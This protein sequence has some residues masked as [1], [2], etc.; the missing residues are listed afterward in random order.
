MAIEVV[1]EGTCPGTPTVTVRDVSTDRFGFGIA[2]DFALDVSGAWVLGAESPF[3]EGTPTSL[4][5]PGRLIRTYAAEGGERVFNPT[6]PPEYAYLCDKA[7][8]AMEVDEEASVAGEACATASFELDT[9][10]PGDGL[11]DCAGVCDGTSEL[12]P[13]GECYD[14]DLGGGFVDLFDGFEDEIWASMPSTMSYDGGSLLVTGDSARMRTSEMYSVSRI[15]GSLNKDEGCDDHFVMLSTNPSETWS[16]GSSSTAIKFVWN[17]ST[18]YI[19]ASSGAVNTT[20]SDYRSYDIDIQIDGSTATF[21]D[22][23]CAELSI[24]DTLLASGDPLYV[25]IGADCDGCTAEW[26]DLEINGDG[27][28]SPSCEQDCA[29]E[30]GGS[31]EEDCAGICNGPYVIDECGDCVD[32]LDA[33]TTSTTT[34]DPWVDAEVLTCACDSRFRVGERVEQAGTSGPPVGTMGTVIAGTSSSNMILVEWD[35]WFSGHNGN[36]PIANC[37]ECVA[38]GSS[39]WWVFCDTMLSH[40]G[41]GSGC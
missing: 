21:A 13:C 10:C 15:R 5:S 37:G 28:F 3:C 20:C 38:S 31:S 40:G 34:T 41:S 14:T 7:Y 1:V 39:R 29:G 36:C 2:E 11:V 12:D 35:D 19:Y 6:I 17:C 25:Y 27:S 18:K 33:T 9:E 8:V 16:W 24:G 23:G 22:D 26:Y 4:A 32:S 30:W